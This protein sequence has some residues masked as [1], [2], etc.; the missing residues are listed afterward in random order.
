MYKF[1]L[2]LHFWKTKMLSASGV[3]CPLTR[4][5]A[6]EPH[7]GLCPQNPVIG[8]CSML[9]IWPS[10][11]YEEVYAYANYFQNAGL[12][13]STINIK[14]SIWLTN[15]QTDRHTDRRQTDEHAYIQF[16]TYSQSNNAQEVNNKMAVYLCSYTAW[17]CHCGGG[18]WQQWQWCSSRHQISANHTLSL[19]HCCRHQWDWRTLSQCY[20]ILWCICQWRLT[21][22]TTASM[23]SPYC[24]RMHS[25]Q[26]LTELIHIQTDTIH[27]HFRLQT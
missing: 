11:F 13:C 18:H 19:T 25:S 22:A 20:C 6:P 4:S 15:R 1:V 10:H 17:R 2:Y 16:Q 3:L 23:N 9:T 14:P 7:L 21:A 5:S 24:L 12:I 8:S 26:V 27:C